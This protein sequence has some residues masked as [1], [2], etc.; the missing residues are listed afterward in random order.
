[1]NILVSNY[2]NKHITFNQEEYVGDLEPT[3]E[4][5]PQTTGNADAPTMCSITTE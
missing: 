4:E 1:M 2:T 3:I 5:I